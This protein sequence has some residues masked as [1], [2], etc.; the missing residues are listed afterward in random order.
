MRVFLPTHTV[1]GPRFTIIL[2]VKDYLNF[3]VEKFNL[4]KTIFKSYS[5]SQFLP[6]PAE[7]VHGV[8]IKRKYQ[9]DFRKY[10]INFDFESFYVNVKF[11]TLKS[12]YS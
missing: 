2:Q 9:I 6:D 12:K 3:K 1:P 8:L 7:N 11:S 10:R 5:E 4:R